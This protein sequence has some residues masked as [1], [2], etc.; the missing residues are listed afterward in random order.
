[1]APFKLICLALRS[2]PAKPAPENLLPLEAEIV[3]QN[4]GTLTLRV[5]RG[6]TASITAHLLNT[7]PVVDLS[8]EDPPI[9][10]VIDQ[11]YQEAAL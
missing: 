3:E 2:D 6:E 7:L 5:P 1:M 11:V 4:I 9:E 10:A 8:V